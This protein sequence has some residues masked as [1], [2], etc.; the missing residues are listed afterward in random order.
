MARKGNVTLRVQSK[1]FC[2]S[3]KLLFK[4]FVAFYNI[5]ALFTY[6][7]TVYVGIQQI[8]CTVALQY[9]VE[10]KVWRFDNVPATGFR[11]KIYVGASPVPSAHPM[12]KA[13]GGGSQ[14]SIKMPEMHTQDPRIF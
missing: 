4:K 2:I 8:Y 13:K 5:V 7:I 14:T 3:Y 1:K 10:G 6:P 11:Y 9:E 12:K